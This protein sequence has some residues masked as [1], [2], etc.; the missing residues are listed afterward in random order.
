MEDTSKE[1]MIKGMPRMLSYNCTEKILKQMKE[2]VCKINIETDRF[3]GTGFI[4]KIPFPDENH[5]LPVL[6]TN[7]HVIS[8]RSFNEKIE[9]FFEKKNHTI[10]I[11]LN[12]DSNR[13]KYTNENKYDVTIIELK[14]REKDEINSYLELDDLIIENIKSNS[15]KNDVFK[16]KTIYIIQYPEGI[17]SVSYGSILS[18]PEDK[19]YNLTYNCCTLGG[20]SGSPIFGEN[21]KIIGIHKEF[22]NKFDYNIGSFL[23]L[24][25]KEFIKYYCP[26]RST[27]IDKNTQ[28]L[29]EFNK[30]Y[31]TDIEDIDAEE[32]NLENEN[33]KNEGTK[34]L[35]KIEFSNLKKLN[36]SENNIETIKY[37]NNNE[38]NLVILNLTRNK[39]QKINIFENSDYP[40]LK[41][42]YLSKNN[43]SDINPLG[44]AKFPKL[45]ILHLNKNQITDISIL[46]SVNFNELKELNLGNNNISDINILE[47]ANFPNLEKLILNGNGISDIIVLKKVEF[48]K[49]KDLNLYQNKISDID[50]LKNSKFE[51]LKKLLLGNNQISDI[52]VLK[53]VKFKKLKELDLEKNN[54][55]NIR[56][57]ETTKFDNLKILK[58][59]YN[60]IEDINILKNLRFKGSLTNLYLAN[61]K[62]KD[63]SVFNNF[64]QAGFDNLNTLTLAK[65]QITGSNNQK[66]IAILKSKL[67]EFTYK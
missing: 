47:N 2:N 40:R 29:I 12:L 62:I 46:K 44:K 32:I 6:I 16:D 48:E 33:I 9:L 23:N 7:N 36:L 25:I 53:T 51:K 11:D 31:K 34:E 39:I 10:K 27:S 55:S 21:N 56:D 37:L 22:S 42:L 61:N 30:K 64:D 41:E 13:I 67:K 19:K 8:E 35:L 14:E 52:K 66:I 43:I 4:C 50:V 38:P 5:M 60:Q 57:L 58:L 26:I 63:I 1:K 59:G 18:I 54:I 20:S 49:L 17:L 3:L 45:E 24:P 28:L 15:N 65:N